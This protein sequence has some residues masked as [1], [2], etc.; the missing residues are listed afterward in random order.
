MDRWRTPRPPSSTSEQVAGAALRLG[1]AL[2]SRGES[3]HGLRELRRANALLPDMTETLVELG[4][5][6]A[7]SGDP[8]QV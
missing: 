6:E 5:K 8:A 3:D 2:L 1:A 4:K 7:A